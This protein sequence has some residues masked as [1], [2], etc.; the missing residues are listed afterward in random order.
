MLS[1]ALRREDPFAKASIAVCPIIDCVSP[2]GGS[3]QHQLGTATDFGI[4]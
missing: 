2:Q 4:A 1:D 3:R